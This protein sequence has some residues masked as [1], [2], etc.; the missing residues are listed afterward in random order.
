MAVLYHFE[1]RGEGSWE[2]FGSGDGDGEEP[3]GA[4][5]AGG[6]LPEGEYRCIA[7]NQGT[8]RWESVWLDREGRILLG[9]EECR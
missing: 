4:A 5:L 3:I 7:A 9:A 6:T 8:T 1:F 2:A